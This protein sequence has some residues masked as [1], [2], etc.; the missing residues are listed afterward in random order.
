[1]TKRRKRSSTKGKQRRMDDSAIRDVG[2]W[3]ERILTNAHRALD[4]ASRLSVD[5][6]NE[7]NDL[8]WALAK[9]AENVQESITQLDRI[10]NKILPRLI[11]I[12]IESEA[13]GDTAWANLKGMRIRLAH[14]FWSIDPTVLWATVASDFPKLIALIS[15]IKLQPHPIG[16]QVQPELIFRGEEVLSLPFSDAGN[17]P[18]LGEGILFLWFYEDGDFQVLRVGRKGPKELLLSSATPMTLV[19][20]YRLNDQ[21]EGSENDTQIGPAVRVGPSID[22]QQEERR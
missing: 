4:L 11:E 5:D 1:M 15:K 19:G 9:Y 20:L 14:K 17:K 16:K 7:S 21:P 2:T 8:F 18:A 13:E 10:N 12:P 6:C 3:F 22:P